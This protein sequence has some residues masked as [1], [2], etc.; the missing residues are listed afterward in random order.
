MYRTIPNHYS[1]SDRSKVN[2][3]IQ[4]KR[5]RRWV[6]FMIRGRP[7]MFDTKDQADAWLKSV[8]KT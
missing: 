7:L 2:Y 4:L 1:L 3:L 5:G 6:N 8:L